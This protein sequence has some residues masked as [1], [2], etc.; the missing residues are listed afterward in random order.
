M[1]RESAPDPEDDIKR[2]SVRLLGDSIAQFTR[3]HRWSICRVSVFLVVI[4]VIVAVWGKV[5][6]G[7]LLSQGVQ[8]WEESTGNTVKAVLLSGVS[9]WLIRLLWTGRLA[10]KWRDLWLA[11]PAIMICIAWYALLFGPTK[12]HKIQRQTIEQLDNQL[13]AMSNR[14]AALVAEARNNAP[15]FSIEV[16]WIGVSPTL[17]TAGTET[18]SYTTTTVSL[19]LTVINQGGTPSIGR[20]CRLALVSSNG[21][22][23][24]IDM[25]ALPD[26]AKFTFSLNTGAEATFSASDWLPRK[27]GEGPIPPGDS[28]SGY[29][30]GFAK[31]MTTNDVLRHSKVR[32]V[33]SDY[34]GKSYTNDASLHEGEEEVRTVPFMPGVK[35][36][37]KF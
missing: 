33:L 31:N 30:I 11:V 15:N 1:D 14:V 16:L 28:K 29:V 24:P 12:I 26:W 34:S 35:Q 32:F 3:V 20:Q 19:A 21:M 17:Q 23:V 13:E 9:V 37:N 4:A 8:D 6:L 36:I 25:H 22:E 10:V 2:R 18:N 7:Q 5:Y 27:L